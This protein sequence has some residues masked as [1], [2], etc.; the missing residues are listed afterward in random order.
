MGDTK[1]ST[2]EIIILVAGGVMLIA[3]FLA[4]WD[5]GGET[6]SAWGEGV[7]PFGTFVVLFGVASAGVIAATKFGNVKLPEKVL[8]LDWGQ[9]HVVLGIWATL[10]M[11]SFLIQSDGPDKGIGFWLLLLG[12]IALIVG[13]VM[14]LQESP[15]SAGPGTAPPTPF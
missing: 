2:S 12:S 3:G 5:Q 15:S 4:F 13:A 7:L 10:L 9:I 11:L 8:G 14:R 6:V 1:L